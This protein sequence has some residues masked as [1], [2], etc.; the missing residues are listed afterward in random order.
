VVDPHGHTWA[1]LYNKT[2]DDGI[3]WV[4]VRLPWPCDDPEYYFGKWY[5][6]ATV[7]I[8]CTVYN[9]T[10]EFKYDYHVRVWKTTIDKDVYNH[11]EYITVT[12]EFGTYSMTPFWALFTA[13]ATD[14]TGVPF[15]FEATWKEV[16]GAEW[17]TYANDTVTLELYIPKFARAGYP[18]TIWIGVLHNW[19]VLGGDAIFPTRLPETIVYFSINPS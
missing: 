12:I 19:P 9:D 2:D 18:A 7:D 4:F 3:C 14:V 5:I 11:G 16:G 13:T 1:I 8:A 6:F 15:D 17:C 10:M